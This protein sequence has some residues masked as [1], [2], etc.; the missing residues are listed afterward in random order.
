MTICEGCEKEVQRRET[1]K[2]RKLCADCCKV[3]YE[4][5]FTPI[6]ELTKGADRMACEANS[7]LKRPQN[8]PRQADCRC[9]RT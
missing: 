9:L 7:I 1:F 8:M 5:Q 4:K 3:A 6:E 2:G